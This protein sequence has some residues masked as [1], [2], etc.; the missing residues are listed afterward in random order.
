MTIPYVICIGN[1]KIRNGAS[2]DN[3]TWLTFRISLNEFMLLYNNFR[4]V[5]CYRFTCKHQ[6]TLTQLCQ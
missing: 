6:K 3:Y 1:S 4:E 5:I 2:D